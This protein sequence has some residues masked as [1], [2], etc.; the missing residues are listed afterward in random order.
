MNSFI[1]SSIGINLTLHNYP[2]CEEIAQQTISIHRLWHPKK[3]GVVCN[4]LVAPIL[5]RHRLWYPKKN[6]AA[7]KIFT[8][9][10]SPFSIWFYYNHFTTEGLCRYLPR[11]RT[12]VHINKNRMYSGKRGCHLQD[13]WIA[14]S[15]TL[16][17]RIVLGTSIV[18]RAASGNQSWDDRAHSA[19]QDLVLWV[20]EH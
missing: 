6:G 14:C 9:P 5:R 11:K 4:I 20:D 19:F 15:N 10:F 18:W 3:N 12:L 13:V 1:N 8:V 2:F 16:L 17:V 7:C